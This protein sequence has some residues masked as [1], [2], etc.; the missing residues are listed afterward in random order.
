MVVSAAA[1]AVDPRGQGDQARKAR[2]GRRLQ[3]LSDRAE[4]RRSLPKLSARHYVWRERRLGTL[5]ASGV[6]SRRV[7]QG[8]NSRFCLPTWFVRQRRSDRQRQFLDL[9]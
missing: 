5:V 8:I 4:T 9:T 1:A 2:E 7:G 6:G 3:V